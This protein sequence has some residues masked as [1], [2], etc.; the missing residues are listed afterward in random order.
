MAGFG[1]FAAGLAKGA[2]DTYSTLDDLER[3][4]KE[5]D[6]LERDMAMR[7]EEFGRLR[8]ERQALRTA[9]SEMPT[10]DTVSAPDFGGGTGGI[11]GDAP[12]VTRTITP[13]E[14]MANFRQRAIA[15]GA[16]PLA[17][18]QFEAGG[19]QMDAARQGLKKGKFELDKLEGDA[20]FDK[21]FKATMQGVYQ[22]SATRLTDI[23]ST[24]ET[25]GMKGLVEKFGPEL[26]QAL[27]ADVSL[28]GNN[29]VVKQKGQKPQTISS[30]GE[31]V[32]ALENAAQME[33]G[34]KLESALVGQGLFKTPQEML[35]YFSGRREEDR[36]TRDT[37]SQIM[38]RGAQANQANAAAGYYAR[39]GSSAQ[40]QTAG[41][42]MQEKIDGYATVLMK[43]NPNMTRA[44]AEKQAAGVILRAPVE[45]PE[46]T[47][48]DINNFLRDQGGS[49]VRVDKSTGKSI[50]LSQLPM[51]EQL[52]IARQALGRSG[53]PEAPGGLPDVDPT[54]M[55]KPGASPA[56]APAQKGAVPANDRMAPVQAAYEK[57]QG[58]KGPWYLP[59]PQADVKY[60]QQLERE[61]EQALQQYQAGR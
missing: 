31:A 36:K 14:K 54:K 21:K 4:K 13:E 23:R 19:L 5:S 44:E 48:A 7:E 45:K 2:I 53:G 60:L 52:R 42:A 37:D 55:V 18:Q 9:I 32:S 27:G 1:N 20:E 11:D 50:T 10:G 16:D 38:L 56:A 8:T 51:E 58:A 40:R 57:W 34:K 26:K 30:L 25:G 12:M 61:Y 6:R 15:L 46:Y 3:K 29:I 59:T 17:V 24:A 28:V 41:Q 22:H 47:P 33:F 35:A 49:V 43:A 39:G